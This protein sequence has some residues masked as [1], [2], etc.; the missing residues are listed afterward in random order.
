MLEAYFTNEGHRTQI[1]D[2]IRVNKEG[3]F[4]GIL[5][6]VQIKLYPDALRTDEKHNQDL[7]NIQ[8]IIQNMIE[9]L[10]HRRTELQNIQIALRMM[11]DRIVA[12][13][14]G[15]GRFRISRIESCGSMAENTAVLKYDETGD[16]YTEC[17]YLA[18]LDY[19][20]EIVHR[21]NGCRGLCVEVSGLPALGDIDIE[22][23]SKF[24]IT[25]GERVL[26]DRLFWRELHMCM[27]CLCDCFTVQ[28][29]EKNAW[30]YVS[31]SSPGSCETN[32]QTHCCS[33]A[34]KMPTGIL[35]VNG[36]ISFGGPE[37]KK[38]SLAFICTSKAKSL[39]GNDNFFKEDP[40]QIS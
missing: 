31:Y 19:S 4:V 3:W 11:L 17:D 35:K 23:V 30:C 25:S 40:K 21:G 39:L 10:A 24:K 27:G 2:V 38:C 7:K 22:A 37:D 29:D 14:N 9:P 15:R 18:V 5:N 13:V 36:S 28:F 6:S 32:Q 16:K 34:V 20:A 33:C 26:C 12:K 1:A 8:K